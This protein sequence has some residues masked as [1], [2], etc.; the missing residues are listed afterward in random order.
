MKQEHL[1]V[2]VGAVRPGAR[3][4]Y[5][6]VVISPNEDGNFVIGVWHE[7]RYGQP[8]PTMVELEA[9]LLEAWR[10][11]KYWEMESAGEMAFWE[12]FND[13]RGLAPLIAAFDLM[14]VKKHKGKKLTPEEEAMIITA[15][16]MIANAKTKATAVRDART[17]DDLDKIT[18]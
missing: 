2:A 9:A 13:I 10:N 16:T 8:A 3:Q 5:D 1:H 14:G 7:G 15:E 6:Y 18:F 12:A 17:V 4:G 11:H